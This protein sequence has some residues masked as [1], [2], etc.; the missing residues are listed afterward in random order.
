MAYL[1]QAGDDPSDLLPSAPPVTTGG[2]LGAFG[3]V[4]GSWDGRVWP[5]GDGPSGRGTPGEYPFGPSAMGHRAD[6]AA[7]LPLTVD[8]PVRSCERRLNYALP[9]PS[10]RFPPKEQHA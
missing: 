9:G 10:L 2:A 4:R 6:W 7:R 3:A 1:P 5:E 8:I